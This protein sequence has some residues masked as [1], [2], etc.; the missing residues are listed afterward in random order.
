KRLRWM[1]PAAAQQALP[2][3]GFRRSRDTRRTP[4]PRLWRS[5]AGEDGDIAPWLNHTP[6]EVWEVWELLK[7]AAEDLVQQQGVQG[8]NHAHGDPGCGMDPVGVGVLAHQSA[9]ARKNDQRDQRE[10]QRKA[11]AHLAQH[12]DPQRV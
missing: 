12:D 10:G 11:Q 3:P 2:L 8:Q 9:A 5:I 7:L 4:G 1:A 6:W